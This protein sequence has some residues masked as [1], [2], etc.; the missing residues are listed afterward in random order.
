LL[1]IPA[2]LRANTY[3]RRLEFARKPISKHPS[4]HEKLGLSGQPITPCNQPGKV[5]TSAGVSA[6]IDGALHV[7]DRLAGRSIAVKAA[8]Y[9]EYTWQ[10]TQAPK[11]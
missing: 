10:P 6:G 5:V 4:I 7:A 9:M 8:R 3:G 2:D 1:Q 11:K